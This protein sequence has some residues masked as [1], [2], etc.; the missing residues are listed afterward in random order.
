MR[1][2]KFSCIVGL[3]LLW[4]GAARVSNTA[5]AQQ[6]Q[7]PSAGLAG[8]IDTRAWD[9]AANTRLVDLAPPPS[10]VA[11][12]TVFPPLAV[13]V[14]P[15]MPSTNSHRLQPYLARASELDERS[16]PNLQSQT[17]SDAAQTMWWDAIVAQPIGLSAN[18]TPVDINALTQIALASSPFIRGILTE[19]E[20]RQTDVVIADAEFDPLS[21]VE[22]KFADTDE[23]IGSTLTTG[24]NA[25]RFRD[26]TLTSALGI[27][28][29][30]RTG[31]GLELVQRGGFQSNNSTFLIP[32]PQGTS[33]LELNF[34]QPLMRDRGRV[35]NSTRTLL[36]QLD[37]QA[38]TSE[39]RGRLE[40]HLLE[41]TRAYWELFQTRAEFLQK[42]R[43]LNEAIELHAVLAAR[44]SVDTQRRQI[45]R[46][47]VA[48]ARRRSDML[49]LDTRV[50]NAQSRI[51]LLTGDS[52]LSNGGRIELLPLDQPFVG[53]VNLSIRDVTISALE[54]RT[55]IAQSIKNIQ[56]ISAKV[57]AA[58]NQVLP[59]LDLILSSYV[60]GL[61]D[62]RNTFQAIGRQFSD[63]RPSYAAG[64]FFEVP[65]GNRA[66]Q[67]RLKRNQLEL[68]KAVA[69]FEQ[70]AEIAF[71]ETELAVREIHT[72]FAELD[73]RKQSV[74]AASRE[75]NYLV[76]RW[77]LL[78]EPGESAVLL[79]EDLLDAQERLAE[80]EQ[81]VTRAQVN[82]A[83][84]WV[85]LRKTMGVLLQVTDFDQASTENTAAYFQPLEFE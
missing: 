2:L 71:N 46:A 47:E 50:R 58:R 68:S 43:L 76:Q 73:S 31:G 69:E 4:V 24:N 21:F 82:H 29:K 51:G 5:F 6:P 48:V 36:A 77:Q 37:V 85:E 64:F 54:H 39:T 28:R 12:S 27:R 18:C 57:G 34:S 38:A 62:N 30:T 72:T 9:E 65:M 83:L 80:E 33:R 35:V 70:T 25:T 67:A 22:G 79:I 17:F 59:R 45:L 56:A 3:L 78:P 40:D 44:G 74:A 52:Q 16:E 23:P 7:H 26:D 66:N 75:V 8:P 11:A 81:F 13:D 53:Q 63:G 55:D 19:P 15:S 1:Y 60:A 41:V 42:L 84:A 10:P 14:M 32:N 20:I 49:R 61:D